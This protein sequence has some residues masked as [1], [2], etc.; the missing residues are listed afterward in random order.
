MFCHALF[1]QSH[2]LSL[3]LTS[4][5]REIA[6]LSHHLMKLA[7]NS[8]FAPRNRLPRSLSDSAV[9]STSST[10][11]PRKYFSALSRTASDTSHARPLSKYD[12]KV[13]LPSCLLFLC[14]WGFLWYALWANL[15]FMGP[16]LGWQLLSC[17]YFILTC[18]FLY[19]C[20]NLQGV[21]YVN[22]TCKLFL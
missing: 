19:L 17:Y 11:L 8:D 3:S 15:C 14:L 22:A 20:T 9:H 4:S 13:P 7:Q 10:L 16:K 12:R 1:H 2:A 18:H 5:E 21:M 6:A